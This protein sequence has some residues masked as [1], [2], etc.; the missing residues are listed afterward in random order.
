MNL[1]SCRKNGL[2]RKITLISKF[3]TSQCVKSNCNTMLPNILQSKGNQ[4][5]II[6]STTFFVWF[7]K[8][9]VSHLYSINWSNFINWLSLFFEIWSICALQLLLTLSWQRPLSYR[10]QTIHLLPKSV[11][12]FLYDNGLRHERVKQV[13]TS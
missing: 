9:N 10:N 11:D 2:I 3:M 5:G 12:W 6:F 1:W 7:F 13:M 4:S 8:Q